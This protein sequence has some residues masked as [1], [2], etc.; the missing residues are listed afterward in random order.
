MHTNTSCVNPSYKSDMVAIWRMWLVDRARLSCTGGPVRFRGFC[1][2]LHALIE[3][4]ALAILLHMKTFESDRRDGRFI[5]FPAHARQPSRRAFHINN[6]C[7]HISSGDFPIA[8]LHACFNHEFRICF[9]RCCRPTGC[10]QPTLIYQYLILIW[11]CVPICAIFTRTI[12]RHHL[13]GTYAD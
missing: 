8:F 7:W 4:N 12:A 10:Q 13:V 3:K 6:R 2:T 1:S 9:P 11:H 5:M